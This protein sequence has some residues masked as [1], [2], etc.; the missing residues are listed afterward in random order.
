M[1]SDDPVIPPQQDY[2]GR[3]CK[4]SWLR[5][6]WWELELWWALRKPRKVIRAAIKEAKARKPHPCDGHGEVYQRT[7][8]PPVL[9]ELPLENRPATEAEISGD[10]RHAYVKPDIGAPI[11]VD[12]S[13]P[14]LDTRGASD[15]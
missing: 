2:I 14:V 1:T 13:K 7:G 3:P 12:L 15:A 11:D 6:I 10:P 4:A 8:P 9:P 5:R